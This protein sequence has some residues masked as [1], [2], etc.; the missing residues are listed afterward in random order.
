MT[1][2]ASKA[3]GRPWAAGPVTMLG[4]TV[5]DSEGGTTAA[6]TTAANAA[7]IV[8]RVNG[9]E[10]LVAERD[11]LDAGLCAIIQMGQQNE[12]LG[13]TGAGYWQDMVQVARDTR[14]DA[15]RAALGKGAGA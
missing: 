4:W 8:E 9:W 7:L 10:A 6:A 13:A 12:K 3:T 2:D 1:A 15:R 14:R 5:Q 11:A